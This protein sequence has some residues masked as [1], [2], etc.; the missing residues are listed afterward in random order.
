VFQISVTDG[1]YP[2]AKISKLD[3]NMQFS[4]VSPFEFPPHSNYW[5]GLLSFPS[6]LRICKNYT[7]EVWETVG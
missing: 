6:R 4:V 2:E 5:P 7:G 3:V 1:I